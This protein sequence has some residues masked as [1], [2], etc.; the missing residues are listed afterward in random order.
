ML[1]GKGRADSSLRIV[2]SDLPS[3]LDLVEGE[4][5]LVFAHL[6]NLIAELATDRIQGEC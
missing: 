1:D 4:A 5:A 2:L 3:E 6:R